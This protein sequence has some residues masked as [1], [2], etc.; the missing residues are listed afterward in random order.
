MLRRRGCF[1]SV[2]QILRFAQDDKRTTAARNVV[3]SEAKDL[4]HALDATKRLRSIAR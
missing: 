2:V 1:A 3:L 4:N